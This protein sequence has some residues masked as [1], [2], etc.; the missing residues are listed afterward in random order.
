MKKTKKTKEI[1]VEKV[2]ERESRAVTATKFAS[3]RCNICGGFIPEGDDVCDNGH[4]LGQKYG[5]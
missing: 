2:I 4:M 1:K 5:G 3:C